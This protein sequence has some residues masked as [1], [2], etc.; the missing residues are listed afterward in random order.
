MVNYSKHDYY[1][2]L[3]CIAQN[4]ANAAIATHFFVQIVHFMSAMSSADNSN[5][6]VWLGRR[7]RRQFTPDY[8]TKVLISQVGFG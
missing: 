7:N 1:E 3:H 2:T 6:D 5:R 8:R 4:A